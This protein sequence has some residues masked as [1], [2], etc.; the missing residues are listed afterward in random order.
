VYHFHYN[1]DTNVIYVASSGLQEFIKFLKAL[2]VI[3]GTGWNT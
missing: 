2:F 3:S 1:T